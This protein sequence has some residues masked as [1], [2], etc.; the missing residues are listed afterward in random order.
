MA[1]LAHKW[2]KPLSKQ[3]DIW[4]HSV[5]GLLPDTQNY[6]LRMRRECFPRHHGL[7][8]PTFITAR[9]ARAVLHA[10]IA[11]QRFPLK[12]VAGKTFPVW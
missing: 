10:G 11:K 2:V 7:A 4:S 1:S 3:G 5:M 9:P 8:I 12:S 6:G